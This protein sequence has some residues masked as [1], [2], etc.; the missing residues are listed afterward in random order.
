MTNKKNELIKKIT[1]KVLNE[2]DRHREG[3]WKERWAKQKAAKQAEK[4]MNPNGEANANSNQNK[5]NKA[6]TDRHR[7]GYWKERWANTTKKQKRS[8]KQYFHD[9]NQAHPERLNRG[10]TKGYKNGNVADGLKDDDRI[11]I[12]PGEYIIGWDEF[13]FPI[14]NNPFGDMI[15][16]HEAGFHDD[17]WCESSWADE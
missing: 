7:E 14:T 10:Y 8:R 5:E 3:Y 17:D 12:D 2:V 6:K 16:H 15:R 13:G 4:D 9:Y 11:W 1:K